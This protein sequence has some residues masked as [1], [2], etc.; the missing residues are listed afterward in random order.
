MEENTVLEDTLKPQE[1]NNDSKNVEQE[2]DDSQIVTDEEIDKLS[3]E[4]DAVKLAEANKK[5][6]ARAKKAETELKAIKTAPKEVVAEVKTA[7]KIDDVLKL[8]DEKVQERLDEVKLESIDISDDVKKQIKNYAKANGLK[9]G[10]VLKS[11]YFEFL[12]QKEQ[13]A[14]K[15]DQASIG[16]KR[17]APIK[18][19]FDVNNPPKVD[20]STEEGQKTWNEYKA[21]LKSQQ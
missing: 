8:I 17:N 2:N 1:E 16:G 6:F 21:F 11:D 10:Q 9:I 18:T 5:L 4:G 19:E 20:F 3:E 14:N 7:P 15:V 13:S 12:K